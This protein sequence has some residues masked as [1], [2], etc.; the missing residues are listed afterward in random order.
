LQPIE[1]WCD[2]RR[3]RLPRQAARRLYR[4]RV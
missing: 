2:A 3:R 4:E 1:R